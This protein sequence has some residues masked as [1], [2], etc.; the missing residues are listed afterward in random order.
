[1]TAPGDRL[2]ELVRRVIERRPHD[3]FGSVVGSGQHLQVI[4]ER[5]ID[6]TNSRAPQVARRY[7]RSFTD[8][9]LW[10]R[11]SAS[12]PDCIEVAGY[13][14]EDGSPVLVLGWTVGTNP[15]HME[16]AIS[17]HSAPPGVIFAIRED[18]AR[19]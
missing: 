6:W 15:V 18:E 4:S 1:M 5:D 7:V 10:T 8:D 14:L 2:R 12:N 13:M 9:D 16:P 19:E 11:I 17:L 3:E